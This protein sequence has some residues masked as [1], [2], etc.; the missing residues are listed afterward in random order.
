MVDGLVEN[1]LEFQ[2]FDVVFFADKRLDRH[3]EVIHAVVNRRGIRLQ[4]FGKRQGLI[5]GFT[6][7]FS[8]VG[9]G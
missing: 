7:K 1:G 6:H 5:F 3:N 4:T 8:F 9:K 2:K